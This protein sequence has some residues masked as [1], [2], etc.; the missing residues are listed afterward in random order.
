M[1]QIDRIR[2]MNAEELAET[3]FNQLFGG[4]MKILKKIGKDTTIY[5]GI[6]DLKQKF[7]E[8]LESE[9]NENDSSRIN[10]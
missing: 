1:K 6:E 8:W 2:N 7:I 3:I 10:M 9:V 5:K 4:A